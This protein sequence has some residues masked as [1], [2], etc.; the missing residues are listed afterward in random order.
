M[1]ELT[2]EAAFDA[3]HTIFRFIR[4][5]SSLKDGAELEVDR[6]RILDFYLAFPESIGDFK[7]KSAD[8][9]LRNSVRKEVAVARYGKVPDSYYLFTR[10]ETT[11]NAAAATMALNG[12]ISSEKFEV[13]VVELIR[14]AVPIKL[15]KRCDELNT[16][17]SL[18]MK[19]L[20]T[21]ALDYTLLGNNG[22]KSRSGLQDHRYDAA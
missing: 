7:V 4:L 16:S 13:G 17:S 19:F 2:Y 10:M 21:L 14:G 5:L 18:L 1:T 11:Q 20:H 8:V 6:L 12:F 9:K 3:Y 22:L 15:I